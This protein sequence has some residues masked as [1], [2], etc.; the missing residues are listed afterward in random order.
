VLWALADDA[1]RVVVHGAYRAALASSLEFVE[2]RVIRTRI[3]EAG[4]H[5]A[6]TQGPL[7]GETPVL[8]TAGTDGF[9]ESP[10]H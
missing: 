4:L 3:G 8:Q 9:G 10:Q 1:I 2:Q 7:Q 5:Q 6:S